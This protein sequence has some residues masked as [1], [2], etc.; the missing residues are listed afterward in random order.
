MTNPKKTPNNTEQHRRECEARMVMRWTREHR[1]EYY[2]GVQSKRGQ[3]ATDELVAEV[4]KQYQLANSK[5]M[6]L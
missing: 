1:Q 5:E 6:S 2:K 4:K 3:K